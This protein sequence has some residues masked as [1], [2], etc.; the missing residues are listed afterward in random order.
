MTLEL[1]RAIQILRD[2]GV[3]AYPT[4]TVYGVGAEAFN[5][6]AVE[7][8]YRIKQRPSHQPLPLLVAET[9]EL[10]QVGEITELAHHLIERFLPGA[11]TLVM[12]RAE[13]APRWLAGE[14]DKI[15][16]RIPDHQLTISLIQGVGKP[17]VGTSANLSGMPS[18]VTAEDVRQQVGNE[19]D[20]ILD[21]GRCSGGVEST[22]V[23]V[24]DLYPVVLREGA[25][26]MKQIEKA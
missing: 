18:P 19:V 5:K 9:T 1:Q 21:G 4:D 14:D 24:T 13:G 6:L 23:D 26:S 8:I 25:I 12:K 10:Q 15:A 11:L 22:V 2:G 17:I 20:F 7:R 3:V 16:V